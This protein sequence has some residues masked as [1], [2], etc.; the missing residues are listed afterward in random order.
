MPDLVDQRE[1]T[2]ES[3]LRSCLS[4]QEICAQSLY[5]RTGFGRRNYCNIYIKKKKKKQV[6]DTSR[7]AE[8]KTEFLWDVLE[9]CCFT[10][11]QFN[12][13]SRP[14]TGQRLGDARHYKIARVL[15]EVFAVV[16]SARMLPWNL[17]AGQSGLFYYK[18]KNRDAFIYSCSDGHPPAAV[19][20]RCLKNVARAFVNAEGDII[21]MLYQ[22]LECSLEVEPQNAK[23]VAQAVEKI[24]LGQVPIFQLVD[25]LCPRNTSCDY[26]KHCLD[27]SEFHSTPSGECRC[28]YITVKPVGDSNDLAKLTV[29]KLTALHTASNSGG[30]DSLQKRVSMKWLCRCFKKRIY[31][32]GG[33]AAAIINSKNK[34]IKPEEEVRAVNKYIDDNN[35]DMYNKIRAENVFDDVASHAQNAVRMATSGASVDDILERIDNWHGGKEKLYAFFFVAATVKSPKIHDCW[36]DP[37]EGDE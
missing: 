17:D 18:T 36:F 20:A 8:E 30:Y 16:M 22:W 15:A 7:I 24:Y 26:C 6:T 13:P 35:S 19:L 37:Y 11:P 1:R 21:D 3:K 5:F 32:W 25:R 10:A 33:A 2:L 14:N 4:W 12:K 34:Q 29:S 28:E 27:Y 31:R 9:C 23:R